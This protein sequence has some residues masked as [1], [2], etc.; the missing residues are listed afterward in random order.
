MAL[1]VRDLLL[2]VLWLGAL[3]GADFVWRGNEMTTGNN[4]PPEHRSGAQHCPTKVSVKRGQI[5]ATPDKTHS[6][7]RPADH[8][9][10]G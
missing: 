10:F 5:A 1:L 7:R 8:H 4:P 9:H 2:P 3:F 6:Q